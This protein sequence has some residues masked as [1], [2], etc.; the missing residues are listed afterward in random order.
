MTYKTTTRRDDRTGATVSATAA[1]RRAAG[2]GMP[3]RPHA[4]ALVLVPS[5]IYTFRVQWSPCRGDAHAATFLTTHVGQT[6][7]PAALRMTR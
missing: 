7:E 2:A 4:S 3:S 6:L 1:R 5:Y